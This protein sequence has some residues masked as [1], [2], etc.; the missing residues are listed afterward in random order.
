MAL[1][2]IDAANLKK[3]LCYDPARKKFI[4]YADIVSGAERII[5]VDTLSPE[6]R[7]KLIVERQKAGPD[8]KLQPMSGPLMTRDDVVKAIERDNPVGLTTVD[9]EVA[10]LGELLDEIRRNLA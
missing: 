9:A 7:K 2:K 1:P 4:Y 10:Y 6:D 8:Y 3:P 5:P